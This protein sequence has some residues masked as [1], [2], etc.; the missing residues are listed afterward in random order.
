MDVMDTSAN[1]RIPVLMEMVA[2]L[3]R[4]TD[5]KEVLQEFAAGFL[6][7]YGPRGYVS[8]S[9]RGLEPGEYKITRLITDDLGDKLAEADPW[10]KWS[11][12]SVH[13]GGFLGQIIRTA[14]PQAISNLNIRNDPVVGD[15]LARYCSVMAIPLFDN[16]E[17]LN[18]AIT[19]KEDPAGYTVEELEESV[20]RSNLGGTMVKS[21]IMTKQLRE[22]HQAIRHEVEQIARIQRALLP[23]SLPKIPGLDIGVHYET[24]DQAG[25]DMYALRPLRPATSATLIG[26]EC[27]DPSGPW[28]VLIADVSG[29]GPAAAVV[30][31]M[32]QAIFDAYPREPEGPAEVLEHANRHLFAK[33]IEHQFVTALFAIYDPDT[34]RL[35][36]ARAGHNPPVWM[37]PAPGGRWDMAHLDRVGGVPL[38]IL[39]DVAY[40]ETTITL[41]SG[42]TILFY[43]DGITEAMSPEGHMFGT[44]GIENSLTECT[45]EP[46]CAINHITSTLKHHEENVRPTDDQTIVVMRVT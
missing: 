46:E 30:M 42:Q 5:A 18:W 4:A 12:L 26:D 13:R 24:F 21:A 40:E 38:G 45:G 1:R 37:R 34:R 29:H 33:R 9:T 14:Y 20:L 31:A 27:C 39:E 43:T 10:K 11:T 28:G 6:K 32:M 25:G 15:A 44:E 22:A 17:P 2:A 16:G 3:S 35:T 41:D 19:F 8:L 23:A 7:L 36:Y